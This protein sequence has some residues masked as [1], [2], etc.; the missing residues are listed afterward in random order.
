MAVY[1]SNTTKNGLVV[2]TELSVVETKTGKE[3]PVVVAL[4]FER[5]D[6]R[7]ELINIKRAYERDADKIANDDLSKRDVYYMNNKKWQCLVKNHPSLQLANAFSDD[8]ANKPYF[9]RTEKI[10]KRIAEIRLETKFVVLS[11]R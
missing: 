6:G 9:M 5:D 4:H 2:L 8:S 3:S 10:C 11:L 7:L 1:A